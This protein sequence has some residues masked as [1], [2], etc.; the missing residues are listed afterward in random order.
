MD[1]WN[2][3]ATVRSRLLLDVERGRL[4]VGRDALL[5]VRGAVGVLGLQLAHEPAVG[6]P[7]VLVGP[8]AVHLLERNLGASDVCETE[9]ERTCFVSGTRRTR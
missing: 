8:Q 2:R 1:G 9:G 6:G 3:R 5:A 7:G 4:A